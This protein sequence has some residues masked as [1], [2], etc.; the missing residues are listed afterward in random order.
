MD[1][2]QGLPNSGDLGL[3]AFYVY[4]PAFG[5]TEE[6][7]HEKILYYYP[8]D[9][10][11]DE[12]QS[13]VGLCEAF[14][15]FTRTFQPSK[16]CEYVHTE[17]HR[18]VFSEPEEGYWVIMIVA[19]PLS[20]DNPNA[21]ASTTASSSSSA[22]S[23]S[24]PSSSGTSSA[25]SS[26]SSSSS[27][28]AAS[29]DSKQKN[30]TAVS[31]NAIDDSLLRSLI[32]QWYRF[33][34]TFCGSMTSIVKDYGKEE[35]SR[36]LRTSFSQ[37]LSSLDLQRHSLYDAL[38][39]LHFLPLDRNLFLKAQN[40]SHRLQQQFPAIRHSLILS[41]DHVVWSAM[42]QDDTRA[43]YR[44]FMRILPFQLRATHGNSSLSSSAS[45]PS[46]RQAASMSAAGISLS[47]GSAALSSSG[48]GSPF[49]SHVAALLG[50][51]FEGY[52]V[53]PR[54]LPPWW[55]AAFRCQ[56]G[57]V[58]KCDPFPSEDPLIATD[59]VFPSDDKQRCALVI[60]QFAS[61]TFVLFVSVPSTTAPGSPSPAGGSP[62][63]NVIAQSNDLTVEL[64]ASF[65]A[66][67]RVYI[68]NCMDDLSRS[69]NTYYVRTVLGP[70]AASSFSTPT[71]PFSQQ[72][73][74]QSSNALL[75]SPGGPNNAPANA[76]AA[77]AVI[78]G[79]MLSA[80]SAPGYSE[81]EFKYIYFNHMNLALKTSMKR[82]SALPK[83]I[84]QRIGALHGIL[85]R[86]KEQP[87]EIV[88]HS[89][90]GFW[91]LARRAC[92]REI[93]VVVEKSSSIGDVYEEMKRFAS[94]LFQNVFMPLA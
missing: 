49:Q 66:Q 15:N 75:L 52:V 6:T 37:F 88:D 31:Q 38:D 65:F 23:S 55:K 9:A 43:M 18:Y 87:V 36:R 54:M 50:E 92:D 30:R 80:P 39:G 24:T 46:L 13:N 21:S 67:L 83:E 40:A 48:M 44:Y 11:L 69:I 19:L 82:R 72:Q 28:A 78:S 32:D 84:M 61:M 1:N 22:S 62:G 89:K 85:Q 16:L 34:C 81:E 17:R 94:R 57:V 47:P 12:Q 76:A 4:N 63:P 91:I 86:S 42:N 59:A 26:T 41:N 8:T 14:V 27:S 73:R 79:A 77:A 93:V 64:P 45:E 7:E 20:R 3:A 71:V 68:L 51:S 10:H 35:L 58:E 33:F 56:E 90:T 29:D 60:Y 5:P 74:A 53:G 70:A 2:K 25:S